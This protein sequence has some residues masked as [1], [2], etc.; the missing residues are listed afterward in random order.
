[1]NGEWFEAK[2]KYEKEQ[3]NGLVKKV[4]ENFLVDALTYSEAEG[5]IINELRSYEANLLLQH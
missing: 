5:R 3:D 1:M 4:S 2:I